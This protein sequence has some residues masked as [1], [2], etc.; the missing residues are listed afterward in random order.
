MRMS[1][2]VPSRGRPDNVSRLLDAFE[3]TCGGLPFVEDVPDVHIIVDEDDPTK[4]AYFNVIDFHSYPSVY[5]WIAPKGPRGIVHPLNYASDEV[6]DPFWDFNP[7]I[8]GFMGDDHIPRTKD[9]DHTLR[10]AFKELKSGIIYGNDL[11]MGEKLPTAAFL[12]RDIV[13]TLGFMAPRVLGHLYVDNFWMDLGNAIGRL[14]Y[15]PDVVIEHLHPGAGKSEWDDTYEVANHAV[16]SQD[17]ASYEYY[18]ATAFA[19]DVMNVLG[20]I[21]EAS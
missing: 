2:L 18:K 7:D 10:L 13:Q 21:N 15:L 11:L 16:G 12:T 6:F 17:Q 5:S 14:K 1:V 19:I 4:Q 8:L 3:A 9:W 20:C